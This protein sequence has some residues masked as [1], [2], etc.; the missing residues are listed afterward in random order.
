MNKTEAWEFI[1][2]APL[3]QEEQRYVEISQGL[4]TNAYVVSNQKIFFTF[5]ED[6]STSAKNLAIK[7]IPENENAIK[8]I[9]AKTD[10]EKGE[11]NMKQEGENKYVIDLN[12]YGIETG[13]YY[14]RI[15]NEKGQVYQLKFFVN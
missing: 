5:R 12:A 2:R 3:L 7:I 15:T 14:L 11:V 1:V 13:Y 9:K 10:M 4:N 8:N 6:Y